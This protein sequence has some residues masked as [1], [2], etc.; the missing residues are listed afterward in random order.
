MGAARDSL[1]TRGLSLPRRVRVDRAAPPS[2]STILFQ[3]SK[4][5]GRATSCTFL[6]SSTQ[7]MLMDTTKMVCCTSGPT[8]VHTMAMHEAIHVYNDQTNTF[9]GNSQSDLRK[10]EGM[11]YAAQYMAEG[12]FTLKR[13]EDE[14]KVSKP[15][16]ARLRASWQTAWMILD[17][18]RQQAIVRVGPTTDTVQTADVEGVEAHLGFK[19]KCHEIAKVYN[20]QSGARKCCVEF[21]CDPDAKGTPGLEGLMPKYKLNEPFK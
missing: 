18:I 15:S 8:S 10:D 3:R 13:V 19:V 11:A 17:I 5:W 14:L 4:H 2:S 1:R 6:A 7:E 21:L 20:E 12:L 16:P 9:N